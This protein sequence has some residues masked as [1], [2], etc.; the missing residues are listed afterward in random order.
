MRWFSNSNSVPFRAS[1]HLHVSNSAGWGIDF[2]KMMFPI[3]WLAN[4]WWFGFLVSISHHSEYMYHNI[5]KFFPWLACW[6]QNQ[7]LSN[8]M[9]LQFHSDKYC[10][11]SVLI[12]RS[13]NLTSC[14]DNIWWFGFLILKFF[15]SEHSQSLDISTWG[16]LL[17]RMLSTQ[18]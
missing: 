8:Q 18:I 14:S 1:F 4:F 2:C 5:S 9:F 10:V 12:L 15:R 16:L 3:P 17:N 7:L 6:Q 13:N 11:R